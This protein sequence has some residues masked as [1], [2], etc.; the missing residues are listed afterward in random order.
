MTGLRHRRLPHDVGCML[1]QAIAM[2]RDAGALGGPRRSEPSC[3]DTVVAGAQPPGERFSVT[4][5][6]T[7]SAGSNHRP[8]TVRSQVRPDACR[9]SLGSL[10]RNVKSNAAIVRQGPGR[11]LDGIRSRDRQSR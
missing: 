4:P 9:R 1:A 8:E 10:F 11:G 5:R 7:W 3:F 6:M 2:A